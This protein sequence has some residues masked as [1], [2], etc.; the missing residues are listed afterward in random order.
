MAWGCR[1]ECDIA[2]LSASNREDR[3]AKKTSV[4]AHFLVRGEDAPAIVTV[5]EKL[6]FVI[7]VFSHVL[8][9]VPNQ[10]DMKF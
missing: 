9:E 8:P 5:T 1:T 4:Q 7:I 3:F 6:M 2:I 10:T